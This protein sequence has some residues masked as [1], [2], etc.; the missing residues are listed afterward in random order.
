MNKPDDLP[1][2]VFR[3]RGSE[4]SKLHNGSF[5]VKVKL[6][7]EVQ[8]EVLWDAV[9]KKLEEGLKIYTVN[10]FKTE[11][12]EVLRVENAGIEKKAAELEVA[13]RNLLVTN[14]NLMEEHQKLQAETARMREAFSVLHGQLFDQE[15]C[16]SET[17][18]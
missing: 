4:A 8:D 10:D 6:D 14:K 7:A 17:P 15:L 11:L 13:Y 16:E 3:L 12:A 2:V 1:G 9:K 5:S 18:R